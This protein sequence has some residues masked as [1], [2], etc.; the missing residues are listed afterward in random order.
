VITQ[1]EVVAL[2]MKE[3]AGHLW[4]MPVILATQEAEIGRITVHSQPRQIVRGTL[5]RKISIRKKRTG[6]V[7][8]GVGPEFKIQYCKKKKKE[9][10]KEKKMK[11]E[12]TS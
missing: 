7:A 2:K 8:Q 5:S 9:R 11:E 6:G 1:A 10:K 3:E 12:A 4:L